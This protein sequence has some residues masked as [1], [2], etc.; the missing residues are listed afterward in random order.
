MFKVKHITELLEA[1]KLNIIDAMQ[2]IESTVKS[3]QEIN[4]EKNIDAS[5]QSAASFAKNCNVEPEKDFNKH[6]RR[7]LKPKKIDENP[8]TAVV[9]DFSQFYRKEF[10][11]LLDVFTSTVNKHLQSMV[12]LLRP[13]Q[14]TFRIPAVRKNCTIDMIEAMIKLCPEILLDE[15]ECL[16]SEIQILLDA[17]KECNNFDDIFKK[18]C[19]LRN[20]IPRAF[21]IVKLVLTSPMSSASSERS[22]SRLKL[23][24]NHLRTTMSDERLDSLLVLFSAPSKPAPSHPPLPNPQSNGRALQRRPTPAEAVQPTQ[25]RPSSPAYLSLRVTQYSP[26]THRTMEFIISLQ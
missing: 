12:T 25:R 22:F 18:A 20:V 3:F 4:D 8:E 1:E 11:T 24:Y 9:I 19:M 17:S 6:H 15:P 21:R 7:R 16:H 23:V 5:V 2:L 13:F 10:K 26:F 14:E